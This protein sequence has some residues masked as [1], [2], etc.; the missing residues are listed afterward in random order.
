[1]SQSRDW[2]DCDV[3]M[4][5]RFKV[6]DL[7]GPLQHRNHANQRLQVGGYQGRLGEAGSV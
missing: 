2:P 3:E 1:M 4:P 6:V 5:H 7:Y